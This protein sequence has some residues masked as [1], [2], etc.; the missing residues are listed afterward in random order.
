[1]TTNDGGN[2]FPQPATS[3][4]CA[5]NSPYGI[6]GGGLSVRD[7]LAAAALTGLLAN[8]DRGYYCFSAAARA[9]EMADAML[10]AR[11]A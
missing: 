11:R 5:T 9:Y 3:D 6:A 10:E 1:M 2:A 4:G 8:D 7:Y